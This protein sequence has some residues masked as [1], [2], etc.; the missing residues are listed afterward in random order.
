MCM[1]FRYARACVCVRVTLGLENVIAAFC[2]QNCFTLKI[3]RI[4][5]R[6]LCWTSCLATPSLVNAENDG[7][8]STRP[9]DK[10]C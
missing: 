8:R 10:I 9:N 4:P 7:V 5:L 1:C 3:P 2:F 6:F